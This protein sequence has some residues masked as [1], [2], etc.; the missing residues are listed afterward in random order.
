MARDV[1]VGLAVSSHVA[2]QLASATFDRVAV[3]QL[4]A[5]VGTSSFHTSDI[6]SVGAAGSVQAHASGSYSVSGG[7]ADVW[8]TADAFRYMYDQVAGD[9]DVETRV[10]SIDAVNAWTKAGVMI[11]ESLQPGA[12]HAFVAVT[13]TKGVVLQYRD[14]AAG[15]S[16]QA[17]AASATAP[18]WVKLSRRGSEIT[19]FRRTDSGA[20]QPLGT[21]NV[22][23]PAVV[24]LGVAVSSHDATRPA[25]AT[26]DNLVMSPA[27]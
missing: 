21:V 15:V 18:Q 11:R 16:A 19:A 4:G 13:P 2:G 1:F 20:W 22:S 23:L 8:G 10:G 17:G 7:G 25:T 3:A 9:W 24:Y 12:A 26:F 5:P 14:V 6:G 27:P